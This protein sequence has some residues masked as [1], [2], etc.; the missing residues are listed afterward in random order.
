MNLTGRRNND[1]LGFD[2][3][4]RQLTLDVLHHFGE[5]VGVVEELETSSRVSEANHSRLD[6]LIHAIDEGAKNHKDVW[7][8][9][10]DPR[11]EF[12]QS[13]VEKVTLLS[14]WSSRHHALN[15]LLLLQLVEPLEVLVGVE[16]LG[17]ANI[18]FVQTVYVELRVGV[19]ETLGD[20]NLSFKDR[21]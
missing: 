16:L 15:R 9:L 11:H 12:L 21:I 13:F 10:P 20:D 2:A 7:H 1:K 3:N 18:E 8:L 17:R 5:D 6:V 4:L 14:E 19:V